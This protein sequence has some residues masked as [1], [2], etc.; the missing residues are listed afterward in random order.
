M[1]NNLSIT[2]KV[3]SFGVLRKHFG[4]SSLSLRMESR[5]TVGEVLH[6]LSTIFPRDF[7]R[8]VTYFDLEDLRPNA[9]VLV[10]GKEINT[11]NGL[12]TVLDNND[13]IVLIPVSH[14]G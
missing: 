10:N 1:K 13:E 12:E 7:Q 6:K 11:L 9:L 2:I 8:N 14:G 4:K 3:R 5:T